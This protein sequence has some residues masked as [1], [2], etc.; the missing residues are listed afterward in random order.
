[1]MKLKLLAVMGVLLLSQVMYE[2]NT[3]R[4]AGSEPVSVQGNVPPGRT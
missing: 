2:G 3:T 1:M 4:V